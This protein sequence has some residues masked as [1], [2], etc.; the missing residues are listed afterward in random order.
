MQM[1]AY[2]NNVLI[3]QTTSRI[4]EEPT[5]SRKQVKNF[6]YDLIDLQQ[7]TF[8]TTKFSRLPFFTNQLASELHDSV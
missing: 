7:V 6:I 2:C 3:F 5:S 1:K 4:C 8:F